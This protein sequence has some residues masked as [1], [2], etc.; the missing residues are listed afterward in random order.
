MPEAVTIILHWNTDYA[1]IY[2]K[3]LPHV[4][5]RSYEPTIQALEGFEGTVCFNITGHTIDYLVAHFPHLIDQIKGLISAN[6][7][8]MV[9]TGYSH[10]ILPLHPRQR[11]RAQVQAHIDHLSEIFGQNPQG[12]W[13][14]ELAVSPVVLDELARQGIKW[15]TIDQEH[16]ELAQTLGNDRNL[17]EKRADTV[18]EILVEAFWARGLL[19]KIKKFRRALRKMIE[20][21]EK[22]EN[23][24]QQVIIDEK[25]SLP[26][27]IS[28]QAWWNGT[29]VAL[30]GTIPLYS[31]KKLFNTILK[32]KTKYIPLYTSDIEFFGYRGLGVVSPAP[33]VLINFLNKLRKEEINTISPSQI[34]QSEWTQETSF[35][36][37][38]SWSPDKSF[39]IWTDSEDNREFSR[40]LTEVYSTLDRL[41]WDKKLLEELEPYLRIVENSDARGWA[42]LPERKQEAYSALLTIF[43]ML[44]KI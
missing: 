12:F 2:R 41:N 21:M 5:K 20:S 39:R 38:G 22:L 33:I 3:E 30:S 34:P 42:P 18:T 26:A 36:G 11:I 35:I 19:S 37:T 6:I 10:P 25:K 32:S 44:D 17:F 31:E 16:L 4:V 27:Y 24:L 15:V 28:S 8:E 23:A 1:E 9:G 43:E 14:P 40:R 29:R 13:P 7:V